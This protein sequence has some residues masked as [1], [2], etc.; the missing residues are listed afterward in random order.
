[1]E[2]NSERPPDGEEIAM[3]INLCLQQ[4]GFRGRLQQLGINEEFV[5]EFLQAKMEDPA[6]TRDPMQIAMALAHNFIVINERTDI[7]RGLLET[8]SQPWKK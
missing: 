1:M 2:T 3:A 4:N 7:Q 8:L 6:E 5:R